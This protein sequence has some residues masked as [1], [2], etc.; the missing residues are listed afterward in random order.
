MNKWK[1][2]TFEFTSLLP[3][4]IEGRNTDVDTHAMKIDKLFQLERIL[5]N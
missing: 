3:P 5:F 2:L 1:H 4:I